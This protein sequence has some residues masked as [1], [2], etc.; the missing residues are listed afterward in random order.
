MYAMRVLSDRK[1]Y[2]GD[3]TLI[4]VRAARTVKLQAARAARTVKL[5]VVRTARTVKPQAVRIARTVKLQA[6]RAAR[7]VKLQAVRT[8]RAVLK[9][10]IFSE[11]K[12][13]LACFT[14]VKYHYCCSKPA[15]CR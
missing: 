13:Y 7:T 6:V 15:S 1:K 14:P 10:C 5:Q 2:S 4:A 9:I 11:T 3:T 8:V 12:L